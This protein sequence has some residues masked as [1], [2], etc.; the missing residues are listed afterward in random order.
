MVR[1]YMVALP[2]VFPY[3]IRVPA[4]ALGNITNMLASGGNGHPN[5]SSFAVTSDAPS[6]YRTLWLSEASYQTLKAAHIIPGLYP[7][8]QCNEE[9]SHGAG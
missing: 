8:K 3:L 4:H 1:P 5:G 9:T 6:G 7:F 2:E